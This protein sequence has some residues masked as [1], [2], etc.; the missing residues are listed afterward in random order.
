MQMNAVKRP[1]THTPPVRQKISM[2]QRWQELA[3]YRDLLYYMVVRELKGRYKSSVLGF[4]WSLLN[5]L[6]MMLV[7]TVIFTLIMPNNQIQAYPIFLLC[8][9]LP[10]N[11]FTSGVLSSVGSV[12]GNSNLVKKVYFPREIL[13]ISAV[14]AQLINFLLSLLVIFVLLIVF[15]I[16]LS[17]QLW[18]LP[19]VI[20]MQTC[21]IIGVSL[22]LSAINV[23]YRDTTMILDVV[24]MAWF[25]LTPVFYPIDI[26]PKA[27]EA[28][29]LV[30]DVHRLMNI[31]NPMASIVNTYRDIL[32]LGTYTSG[33]FFLRTA[34]TSVV[35]ML[36][37]YWVFNKVSGN[38]GEEL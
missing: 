2:W 8:G 4:V 12:I 13:P 34:V 23:Y 37:G 3:R 32:Y 17:P 18:L 33:D 5:P 7:F 15:R 16:P 24:L 26:L 27:Y 36:M 30:L 38:F 20:V 11:Y 10:W 22:F 9:L 21:F 19:V 31:L 35:V 28:F 1:M 29:G 6:L 14:L 25:F